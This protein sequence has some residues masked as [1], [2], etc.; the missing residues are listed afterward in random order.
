[1]S[2]QDRRQIGVDRHV[3]PSIA[4]APVRTEATSERNRGAGLLHDVRDALSTVSSAAMLLR[5]QDPN[6][7]RTVYLDAIEAA[8]AKMDALTRALREEHAGAT[9]TPPRP[10]E[11]AAIPM[12]GLLAAL[13]ATLS[14]RAEA[15]GLEIDFKVADDVPER[16][17]LDQ[18]RLMRA[19]DNLISN[20]V[21]AA[22][23]ERGRDQH[24][25]DQHEG[26]QL[27]GD[28]GRLS[29]TVARTGSDLTFTLE[30]TGPGLGPEPERWFARGLSGT[31]DGMG[32]GLWVAR[33]SANAM[34]A[35]L[36]AENREGGGARFTLAIPQPEGTEADA[37]APFAPRVL[38]VDANPVGRTLLKALLENLHAHVTLAADTETAL[39]AAEMR[40]YALALID[41]GLPDGAAPDLAR[42]LRARRPD[43]RIAAAGGGGAASR[44][45]AEGLLSGLLQKPVDARALARL[46]AEAQADRHADTDRAQGA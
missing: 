7:D 39:Q 35:A 45:I 38:V 12:K 4:S 20:A 37:D 1:M 36:T 41:F 46:L 21:A 43:I 11:M 8:V 33:R 13:K 22:R 28:R 31:P 32:L 34:H 23:S 18:V 40:P 15:A 16:G 10:A 19:L 5:T 24:K 14:V 25:G 6:D 9:S 26:D 42:A 17:W 27:E 30:D 3:R 2:F 29:L 44:A